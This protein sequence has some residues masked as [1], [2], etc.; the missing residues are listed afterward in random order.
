MTDVREQ[1]AP[2]DPTADAL[3]NLSDDAV[4]ACFQLCEH[5][6][7]L[8]EAITALYECDFDLEAALAIAA[9]AR[10]GACATRGRRFSRSA[11]TSVARL[12]PACLPTSCRITQRG[13]IRQAAWPSTRRRRRATPRSTYRRLHRTF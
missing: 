10:E 12:Q 5:G 9:S 8:S 7:T 6:L 11:P 4:E 1:A 2:P 3:G 13:A